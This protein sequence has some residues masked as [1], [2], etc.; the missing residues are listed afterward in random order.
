MCAAQA[1]GCRTGGAGGPRGRDRRCNLRRARVSRVLRA[2]RP[3]THPGLHMRRAGSGGGAGHAHAPHAAEH[4]HSASS[5]RTV[6]ACEAFCVHGHPAAIPC[7]HPYPLPYTVE[8]NPRKYPAA[9]TAAVV[10]G[11]AVARGRRHGAGLLDDVAPGRAAGVVLDAVAVGAQDRAAGRVDLVAVLA[12]AEVERL[13]CTRGRA[14]PAS[15]RGARTGGA[16]P[17]LLRPCDRAWLAAVRE[18]G[19]SAGLLTGSYRAVAA[20]GAPGGAPRHV[21][22]LTAQVMLRTACQVCSCGPVLVPARASVAAAARGT[23]G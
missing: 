6:C 18:P 5:K 19:P 2:C 11:G 16:R 14:R 13:L 10:P 22:T 12:V 20:C 17:A 9:R 1:R 8:W 23:R 4:A 3:R 21:H 7:E 15:W